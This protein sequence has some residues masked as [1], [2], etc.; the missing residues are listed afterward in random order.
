[1]SSAPVLSRGGALLRA[2]LDCDLDFSAAAR[3]TGASQAV[4]ALMWR[5]LFP[6]TSDDALREARRYIISRRTHGGTLVLQGERV[7]LWL[8]GEIWVLDDEVVAL[9]RSCGLI[10]Q[11][12]ERGVRIIQQPRATNRALGPLWEGVGDV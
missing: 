10:E 11:S 7:E 12:P 3:R 5:M 1:M 4:I 9:C 8:P 6:T 2:L